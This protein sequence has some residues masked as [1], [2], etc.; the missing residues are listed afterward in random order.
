MSARRIVVRDVALLF[1]V[2]MKTILLTKPTKRSNQRHGGVSQSDFY[3]K[4]TVSS[5]SSSPPPAAPGIPSGTLES[6]AFL[7][8]PPAP[9]PLN[10]PVVG[11]DGTPGGPPGGALGGGGLPLGGAPA[12]GGAPGGALGGGGA[13]GGA[14]GGGGLALASAASGKANF[15]SF[16]AA[17][18]GGGPGGNGG[19]LNDESGSSFGLNANSIAL[20]LSRILNDGAPCKCPGCPINACSSTGG[21]GPG[22]RTCL[23]LHNGPCIQNPSLYMLHSF[24]SSSECLYGQSGSLH[25]PYFA[26]NRHVGIRDLSNWCKN[27]H[28]LPFMHKFLN[29]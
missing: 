25:S 6:G 3:V 29:Q 27:P 22:C 10:L 7:F 5:S 18:F 13:P 23:N 17:C 15:S 16:L 21:G 19:G 8:T 20:A 14:L 1:L 24:K 9:Q 11:P 28:A 2:M 12:P 26:K 4:A